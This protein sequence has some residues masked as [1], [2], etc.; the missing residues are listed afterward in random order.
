MKTQ[1]IL[2][3]VHIATECLK[4]LID[5]LPWSM[6]C[7]L[8]PVPRF[9][10]QSRRWPQLKEHDFSKAEMKEILDKLKI[11]LSPINY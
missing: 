1:S 5:I 11:N 7:P 6:T 3:F 10:R 2:A 8:H 9:E 4:P